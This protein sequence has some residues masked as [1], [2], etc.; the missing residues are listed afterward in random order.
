MSSDLGAA[1]HVLSGDCVS[2]GIYALLLH[3]LL[4]YV[5]VI[6]TLV[7]ALTTSIL[8]S[9]FHRIQFTFFL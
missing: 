2:E 7:L 4:V 9:L 8:S 1:N 3:Q 6:W 5:G